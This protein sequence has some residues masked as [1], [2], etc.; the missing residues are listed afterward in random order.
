MHIK[1]D[2]AGSILLACFDATSCRHTTEVTNKS[3]TT[4]LTYKRTY[5]EEIYVHFQNELAMQSRDKLK[6]WIGG[7]TRANPIPAKFQSKNSNAK[8]DKKCKNKVNRL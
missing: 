8:E 3:P 5:P 4:E 2:F 6:N 7:V 1:Q